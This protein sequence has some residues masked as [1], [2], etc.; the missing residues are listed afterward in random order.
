MLWCGPLSWGGGLSDFFVTPRVGLID[1]R[2]APR[3]GVMDSCP[4]FWPLEL[5]LS[6]DVFPCFGVGHQVGVIDSHTLVWALDLG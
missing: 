5:A 4:S 3:V 6:G 2:V 1:S